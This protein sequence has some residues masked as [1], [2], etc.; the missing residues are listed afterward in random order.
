MTF[1]YLVI[2]SKLM[3]YNNSAVYYKINYLSVSL[4][5]FIST[6]VATYGNTFYGKGL[7]YRMF[8]KLPKKHY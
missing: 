2:I 4:E 3:I 8:C 1:R 7:F 5:N 6:D